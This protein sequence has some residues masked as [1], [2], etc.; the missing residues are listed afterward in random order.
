[1][2][3]TVNKI[4]GKT[5]GRIYAFLN[6]MMLTRKRIMENIDN[7]EFVRYFKEDFVNAESESQEELE[8]E[9]A[10]I[11]LRC[12]GNKINFLGLEKYEQFLDDE[13]ILNVLETKMEFSLSEYYKEYR[14]KNF[15]T[16]GELKN[17]RNDIKRLE[18]ERQSKQQEMEI[19]QKEIE[20]LQ[21]VVDEVMSSTSWKVTSPLRKVMR[22]LKRKIEDI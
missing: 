17:A 3:K 20:H 12:S 19:K 6:I 21:F 10:Q 18:A 1:M 4:S 7:E 22:I 9:K 14:I 8:C 16:F 5:D 15:D 13:K 11:L 2:E